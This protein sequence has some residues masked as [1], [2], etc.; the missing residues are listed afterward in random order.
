M[1]LSEHESELREV[2]I[3]LEGRVAE[4]IDVARAI[5][6]AEESLR[7]GLPLTS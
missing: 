7:Y 6:S 5:A 4:M 2:T 3:C 1:E